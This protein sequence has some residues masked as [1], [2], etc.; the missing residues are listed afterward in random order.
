MGESTQRL[1]LPP[2]Q[3]SFGLPTPSGLTP[4]TRSEAES[5][6]M[7][8]ALEQTDSAAPVNASGDG[9]SE[10]QRAYHRP[11]GPIRASSTNYEKAMRAAHSQ[12]SAS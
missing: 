6:F 7:L 10:A 4:N 12:P 5:A 3:G 8:N 9:L 11:G 1:V 2:S